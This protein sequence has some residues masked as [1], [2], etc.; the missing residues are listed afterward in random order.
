MRIAVGA[1]HGGMALKTALK[2]YLAGRGIEV[3]DTGAHTTDASDYPDYAIAVSETVVEG[4]A[5]RGLLL[6]TTGNGMAMAA[7]RFAGIR[8]AVADTPEIASKAS[9]HNHANVLVLAGRGAEIGESE[10]LVAAWLD[11]PF[12]GEERHVRRIAKL[13]VS[14][15]LSEISTLAA[16]DP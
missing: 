16:A 10:R 6:C 4:K 15:R 1:D 7:N 11:T 3:V 13:E 9:S 2:R 8:A 14:G 12:S 5:D